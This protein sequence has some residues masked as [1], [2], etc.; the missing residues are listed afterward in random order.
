MQ[1][2]S[3][4]LF[5]FFVLT[6]LSVYFINIVMFLNQNNILSNTEITSEVQFLGYIPV[7]RRL[8]KNG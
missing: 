7:G 1:L 5:V 2:Y 6:R 3:F 8:N 4:T